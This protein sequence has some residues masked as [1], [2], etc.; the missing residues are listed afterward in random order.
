MT[1]EPQ[2]DDKGQGKAR[3]NETQQSR[4]Y[5]TG[6]VS[7]LRSPV[8]LCREGI[9]QILEDLYKTMDVGTI[10]EAAWVVIHVLMLETGYI[11]ASEVINI[12][13]INKSKSQYKKAIF[14]LIT[15]NATSTTERSLS[16]FQKFLEHLK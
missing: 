6:S 15:N 11:S 8:L 2:H 16:P 7:S 13:Q 5:S 1:P 10:H 3:K 9:P 14:L 12:L 4:G